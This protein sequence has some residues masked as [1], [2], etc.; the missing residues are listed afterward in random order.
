[1]WQDVIPRFAASVNIPVVAGMPVGHDPKVQRT[2]PF[3][4]RAELHLG[5]RASLI[6]DSGIR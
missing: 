2:L 6:V 3:N 4:T 1:L 5:K